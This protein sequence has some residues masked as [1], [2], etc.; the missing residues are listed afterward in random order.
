MQ[1]G[2]DPEHQSTEGFKPSWTA[3]L[4]SIAWFL[5]S[6]AMSLPGQTRP[7]HAL[8]SLVVDAGD[9]EVVLRRQD[10]DA[11]LGVEAVAFPQ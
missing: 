1:L 10:L 7:V 3:T 5:G 2:G 4:S 9:V 6:M 11:G 8:R